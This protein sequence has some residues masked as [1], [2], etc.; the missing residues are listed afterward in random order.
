M[1]VGTRNSGPRL[2]GEISARVGVYSD[3]ESFTTHSLRT[4]GAGI[5][6]WRF[7]DTYAIKLGGTLP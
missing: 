3:F 2:S 5:G 4:M 1:P 7:N 6:V